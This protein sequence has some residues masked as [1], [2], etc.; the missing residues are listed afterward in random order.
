M[1]SGNQR[2]VFHRTNAAESIAYHVPYY[3]QDGRLAYFAAFKSHCSFF[4]ISA[5]DKK[6][7]AKDLASQK[8]VG[9]TLR[10]PQGGKVPA[11]LIQ[12]LVRSRIKANATKRASSPSTRRRR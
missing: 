5:D 10:I 7:Y 2:C 11:A 1:A 4:W 6:T 3:S 8:V 9:S 12:K